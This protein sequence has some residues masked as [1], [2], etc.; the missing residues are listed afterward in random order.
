MGRPPEQGHTGLQRTN[1]QQNIV[2][3]A[4]SKG[5][6]AFWVRPCWTLILVYGATARFFR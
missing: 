2:V 1:D 4:T 6:S 3:T 5:E